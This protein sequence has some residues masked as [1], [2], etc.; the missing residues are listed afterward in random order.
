M[1]TDH[2]PREQVTPHLQN[3]GNPGNS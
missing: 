2:E 1:D 3:L